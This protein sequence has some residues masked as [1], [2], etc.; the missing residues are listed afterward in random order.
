MIWRASTVLLTV[1]AMLTSCAAPA[2]DAI[3]DDAA[4]GESTGTSRKK[5]NRLRVLVGRRLVGSDDAPLDQ[6][7]VVGIEYVRERVAD[8]VG[9]TLGFQRAAEEEM[10]GATP[11]E[12]EMREI[13]LGFRKT[14][15]HDNPWRPYAGAGVTPL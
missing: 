14:L 6:P 3:D 10:Q 1:L 7:P 11:I 4:R 2:Q 15:T 9:L 5:I 8:G 13:Y 12:L